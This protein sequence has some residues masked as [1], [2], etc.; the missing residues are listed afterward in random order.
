MKNFHENYKTVIDIQRVLKMWKMR[1]LT[2]EGKIVIFETIN[3]VIFETIIVFQ[4][5][6]TTVS[7]RII[8]ELEK[9]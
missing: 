7:K 1:N 8:N 3:I 5:F 2:I 4:L 6:I 9:I